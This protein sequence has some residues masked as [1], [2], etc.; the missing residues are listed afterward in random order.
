MLFFDPTYLLEERESDP[1]FLA[2]DS[3]CLPSFWSEIEDS[4]RS[5]M[6]RKLQS[7]F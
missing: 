7:Y 3:L 1:F 2:R 6:T 4:T 5:N